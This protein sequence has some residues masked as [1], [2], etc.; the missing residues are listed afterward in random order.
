MAPLTI[1]CRR[2]SKEGRRPGYFGRRRRKNGAD[3]KQPGNKEGE[4]VD[5]ESLQKR[6]CEEEQQG[7]KKYQLYQK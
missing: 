7:K 2:D 5:E 1:G 6:P 3:Y 4:L